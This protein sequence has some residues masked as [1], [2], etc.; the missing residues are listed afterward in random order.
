M[1][2]AI[3]AANDSLYNNVVTATYS[4]FTD[5]N[6]TIDWGDGSVDSVIFPPASQVT[7]QYATT[8]SPFTI[9]AYDSGLNSLGTTTATVSSVTTRTQTE[10]FK[11]SGYHVEPT[12]QAATDAAYEAVLP[13]STDIGLQTQVRGDSQQ[14]LKVDAAGKHTWGSGSAT[15]DTNLYRSAADTLKTDDAFQVAGFTTLAGAQT[16]GDFASLGDVSVSTAGKTLK[17]KTGSNAKAGTLT[18]N[19]TTAV[20]VSTTAVTANSLIFIGC[21]TPAGTPGA[22]Y[23]SAVTPGTSFQVK[24]V[25]SDTSTLAWFIVEPAA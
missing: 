22:A 24:S 21:N 2:F 14:R 4:G 8:G 9:T 7:H 16:N 19:G 10:D 11:R 15:G 1:P 3:S 23:V 20:T 18:A 5:T 25:A 17:I 13:A 12:S 6:G